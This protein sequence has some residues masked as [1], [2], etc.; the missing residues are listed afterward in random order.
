VK[1]TYIEEEEEV[2]DEDE[3]PGSNLHRIESGGDTNDEG[4]G[5]H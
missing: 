1:S 3:G 2:A 5:T 4:E